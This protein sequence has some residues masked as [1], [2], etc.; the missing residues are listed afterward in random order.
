MKEIREISFPQRASRG[1][2]G[3]LTIHIPKRVVEAFGLRPG[4][5]FIVTLK[6]PKG[7][8]EK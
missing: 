3:R 5:L 2:A 7:A 8:R 1:S 6:R 4:E